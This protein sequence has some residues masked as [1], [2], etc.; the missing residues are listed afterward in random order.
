MLIGWASYDVPFVGFSYVFR[1]YGGSE[2]TS[3]LF[4]G[5]YTNAV[6][7][8]IDLDSVVIEIR[9]HDSY[10]LFSIHLALYNGLRLVVR[11]DVFADEKSDKD[12]GYYAS[13]FVPFRFSVELLQHN[14]F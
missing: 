2:I 9:M 6:C 4:H 11:R 8:T 14:P 5:N 12:L 1:L 7:G 10:N 3:I 13:K